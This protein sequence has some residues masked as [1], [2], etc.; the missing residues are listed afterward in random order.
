VNFP[1]WPNI[2]SVSA[3]PV[4]HYLRV[5]PAFPGVLTLVLSWFFHPA[6]AV[7]AAFFVRGLLSML[8]A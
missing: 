7:A 4:G 6:T 2:I 8:A 5:R 3:V 1:E